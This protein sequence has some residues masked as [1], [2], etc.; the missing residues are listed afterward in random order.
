MRTDPFAPEDLARDDFLG[1][2]VR[3]WQPKKGYRAGADPVLLSATVPA[4]QGDAVLELGCG[5]GAA[6]ACL[7]ARVPGIEATGVEMQPAYADLAQRN[8]DDNGISGTIH[9]ADLMALPT[10]V[11]SRRFDHVLANPPYFEDLRAVAPTAPDRAVARSGALPLAKWVSVASKRLA[12][13]G[14]ATFI[15]RIDRLPEL[16][17]AFHDTLGALELWLIQP[18]TTRPAR[19]FLLRGRKGARAAFISHPPLVLHRGEKHEKDGDSYTEAVSKVLRSAH[20]LPFP[21]QRRS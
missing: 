8:L 2:A 7:G 15:Q 5:G 19:L 11:K 17:S 1:G 10:A 16:M 14:M 18:R 20:P 9:C 4:V 12:P 13:G 21:S 6:L 3:L